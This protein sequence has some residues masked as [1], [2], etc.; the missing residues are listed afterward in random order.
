RARPAPEPTQTHIDALQLGEDLRQ[1]EMLGASD[2]HGRT[3]HTGVAEAADAFA[4]ALVDQ[5]GGKDAPDE[6]SLPRGGDIHFGHRKLRLESVGHGHHLGSVSPDQRRLLAP[7]E[8]FPEDSLPGVSGR[9]QQY[10]PALF[11]ES[12]FSYAFDHAGDQE[13]RRPCPLTSSSVAGLFTQSP[14]A[15]LN[16]K[17]PEKEGPWYRPIGPM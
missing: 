2:G 12:A 9:A 11:H 17:T 6:G 8:Q 4:G 1:A 5:P 10:D 14:F 7:C 16:R 3:I 15:G 13:R